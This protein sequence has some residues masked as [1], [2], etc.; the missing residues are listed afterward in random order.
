MGRY[1][2]FL[3]IGAAKS[4]TTSLYQYLNQHP[5]IYMSSFKEPHFFVAQCIPRDKIPLREV[6]TDLAEYQ[7][8]FDGVTKEKVFGE[9]TSTYLTYPQVAEKIY[10]RI[11]NAKLIAIL[12]NPAERAYS[13]FTF[14]LQLGTES[15][16]NFEEALAKDQE[17]KKQNQVCKEY[18][19]RGYY[20]A[21]LQ[22]YYKFFPKEQIKV[23]LYDDLRQNPRE[24]LRDI[25]QFLEVDDSFTVNFEQIYNATRKVRSKLLYRFL[26]QP[27]PLHR[28]LLK[29]IPLKVR[30][31]FRVYE[32]TLGEKFPPMPENIKIELLKEYREDI[33]S[34]QDLIGR[35]LSMWLAPLKE[36]NK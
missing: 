26:T 14:A 15:C 31:M 2:N 30:K 19:E 22:N 36:V 18:K 27:N 3:I 12:R 10:Q 34:L 7:K 17:R 32:R 16:Q 4:G 28:F 33:L 24:L 21:H 35:D 23:C 9:A 6:I 25:F 5:E 8:L 1:P 20:F 13:A 29:V 11:P